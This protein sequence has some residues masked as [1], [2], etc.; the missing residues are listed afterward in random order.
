MAYQHRATAAPSPLPWLPLPPAHL[1]DWALSLELEEVLGEGGRR[2]VLVE[3]GQASGRSSLLAQ[4]AVDWGRGATYLQVTSTPPPPSPS[5]PPPP[6]GL[7]A[8]GPPGLL[9][10]GPRPGKGSW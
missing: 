3:G 10:H 9:H 7:P 8:G 4:L 1:R 2:A 5:P 6:P